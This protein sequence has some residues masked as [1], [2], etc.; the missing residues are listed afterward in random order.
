MQDRAKHSDCVGTS[1]GECSWV[2]AMGMFRCLR[3]RWG[4]TSVCVWNVWK[5][6]ETDGW[7]Q[8]DNSYYAIWVANVCDFMKGWH[9]SLPWVSPEMCSRAVF[10][11]FDMFEVMYYIWQLGI[12]FFFTLIPN[13]A[14]LHIHSR[15]LMQ[16]AF[17]NWAA[18]AAT[19]WVLSVHLP[20][21]ML[22]HMIIKSRH[23]LSDSIKCQ[24]WCLS[25]LKLNEWFRSLNHHTCLKEA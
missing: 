25:F 7:Y 23:R 16:S 11:Q 19:V 18:Q 1:R 22:H 8:R 6:D 10:L 15:L 20:Y 14:M 24:V 17:R 21:K 4:C 12:L 5:G 13:N 3:V 9:V 2:R